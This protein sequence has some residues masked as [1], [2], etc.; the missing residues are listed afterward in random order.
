MNRTSGK[1]ELFEFAPRLG[2]I[3]VLKAG[4]GGLDDDADGFLVETF[5][6]AFALEVFEMTADGTF[7]DELVELFGVDKPRVVQ[8][9]GAF[10]TNRPAFA[11]G[12]GLLE[13]W[14]V[15]DVLFEVPKPG[16]QF[17]HRQVVNTKPL[18]FLMH[19]IV[20][21]RVREA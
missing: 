14:K 5:E 18:E 1:Q 3:C 16:S 15:G 19:C 13:E 7:A 20:E 8:A 10:A 9:L 17:R 21:N 4:V 2:R 11:L 6:A 12:E